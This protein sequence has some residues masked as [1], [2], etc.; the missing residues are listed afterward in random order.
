MNTKPKACSEFDFDKNIAQVVKLCGEEL[1]E[2]QAKMLHMFEK[3]N[4]VFYPVKNKPVFE[5][6]LQN[7]K[8]NCET[9]ISL[10]S[11]TVLKVSYNNCYYI[12]NVR[13]KAVDNR[14]FEQTISLLLS[15]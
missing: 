10:D 11:D 5:E 6:V 12:N 3:R 15:L 1:V 8:E 7:L 9:V 2:Q 14:R 4:R 13:F